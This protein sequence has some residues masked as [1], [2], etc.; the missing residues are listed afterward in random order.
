MKENQPVHLNLTSPSPGV[1]VAVGGLAF[2]VLFL[3]GLAIA[4]TFRFIEPTQQTRIILLVTALPLVGLAGATFVILR[5]ARK[6]ARADGEDFWELMLPE[7]QRR[8]LN[9]Q[10]HE[11]AAILGIGS[12]QF[13]DLRAAYIL[14]ED[15][16]IR[17]IEQEKKLPLKRHIKV[18]EAQFDA[19]FLSR[20]VSTFVDVTFLVTSNISQTKIDA[21]LNKIEAVKKNFKRIKSKSKIKLMLVLVTQLD[22]EDEAKLRASLATKFA[23]TPVDVDIRLLDF[24]GLQRIFTEE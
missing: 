15:L 5:N 19:V 17:Q 1:I 20:D 3:I 11:L 13:S 24:E 9:A 22:P 6:L 8:K 18:G 4:L 12:E 16:A 21:I 10:V 14:A 7:E 2:F 23:S